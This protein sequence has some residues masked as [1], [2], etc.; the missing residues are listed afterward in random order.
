MLTREEDIVREIVGFYEKLYSHEDPVFRGFEGV[1]WEGITNFLSS[2]IERPFTEEEVKQAVFECDGSKAPGPDGYSMVVFQS[3]WNILKR[4]IMKVFDEFYSSGIINEI[5]N[6]TYIR[7]IP[8][9]L[10]SCRVRVLGQLACCLA[11][12]RLLLRC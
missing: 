11:C 6:E 9:K 7:L 10:N 8:K 3:Q 1:E 4:D 12:T 2:W 5:T